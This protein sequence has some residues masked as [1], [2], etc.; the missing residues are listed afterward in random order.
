MDKENKDPK[1]EAVPEE[2]PEI[3]AVSQE[4]DGLHFDRRDFVKMAGAAAAGAV[5]FSSVLPGMNAAAQSETPTR[6]PSPTKTQQPCTVRAKS[7]DVTVHVGPGRNRGIRQYLPADKDFPVVGQGEDSNGD[8]WWQISLS[9]V[10][11]AW[12]AD[13]DVTTTGDCAAIGVS[14]TPPI[15]TQASGQKPTATKKA[16]N[17][18][19][20]NNNPP[21][22]GPNVPNTGQLGFT[23][24]GQNGSNY[25]L[26]GTDYYLPCGSAIPTGA[27]C[28]CNCVEVPAAPCSCDT[29]CTCDGHCTCDV[30]HNHYW[31]PN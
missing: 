30:V 17:N 23:K 26:N 1:Q 4:E 6:T 25:N 10:A 2:Q 3:F 11:Q 9:K 29:V 5:V 22:N 31:Y 27:V 12:V 8:L 24:E 18:N 28:T 13:E 14:P 19:N 7:D 20:N 16:P 15:V 21:N